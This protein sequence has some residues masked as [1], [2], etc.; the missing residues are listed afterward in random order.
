MMLIILLLTIVK[1]IMITIMYI[2]VHTLDVD[3]KD[4]SLNI[5]ISTS[6]ELTNTYPSTSLFRDLAQNLI[7]RSFPHVERT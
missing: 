5:Y 4:K 6:G 2:F 1:M 3:P 7:F